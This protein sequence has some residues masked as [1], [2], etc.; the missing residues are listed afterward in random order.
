[1]LHVLCLVPHTGENANSGRLLLVTHKL[2]F[3]L[4]YAHAADH[5]GWKAVSP[6]SETFNEMTKNCASAHADRSTIWIGWPGA[7]VEPWEQT[8]IRQQLLTEHRFYP[9]FLNPQKQALFYEGYCKSVLWPL[10]HS[11]PPTTDDVM[12][13][14]D[15]Y[16]EYGEGSEDRW[17][18]RSQ[19]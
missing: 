7:Q 2:P 15:V 10:F 4:H 17:E 19:V 16:A 14:H 1:M 12:A 9:V 5:K 18:V 8:T 6:P 3:Q 11:S 13:N